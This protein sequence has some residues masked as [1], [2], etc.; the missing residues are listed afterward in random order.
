M[1][2]SICSLDFLVTIRYH[3]KN[4]IHRCFIK[5][6]EVFHPRRAM[7]FWFWFLI[8]SLTFVLQK[9]L[10]IYRIVNVVLLMS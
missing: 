1:I 10:A 9:K 4:D 3:D 8:F 7:D 5:L 6:N 2:Y